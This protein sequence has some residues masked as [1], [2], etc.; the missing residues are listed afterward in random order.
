MKK[1]FILFSLILFVTAGCSKEGDNCK[2]RADYG[3][4][5]PDCHD[6]YRPIIF[7]HGFLG[8]GDNYANMVQRFIQNGYCPEKLILYDW[9]TQSGDV[10]LAV[11]NLSLLIDTVI[12]KS[13][14]SQVDLIGHSM[15]GLVGSMYLNREGSVSKIA[16]YVHAASFPDA[17]FP[18]GVHVMTISSHDDTVVGFTDIPGAIN[19][20][21]PG[22]DHIQVVTLPY[23]FQKVYEFFNDGVP[24][25]SIEIKKEDEV[26]IEGKALSIGE[27]VPVK[28]ARIEIYPVDPA[29]G[30]RLSDKSSACFI[31]DDEGKWGIFRPQK[32]TYYEIYFET[33]D[34][35]RFHYYRQPFLQSQNA[36]YLRNLG[37]GAGLVGSLLSN[38]AI[39]SDEYSVMVMFS[40]NQAIYYGRD[41]ISIDGNNLATPE[42]TEP[43]QSS[44]AFFFGDEN[45]NG[46]S[47]LTR[48]PL[49][50][51][52]FLE[53]IDY[54]ISTETRKPVIFEF[55]GKYLAVPNWKSESEGLGIAVFD[56]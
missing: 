35:E 30:E 8:A 19:V 28:D 22:A 46:I 20:E 53:D 9:N 10:T 38:I 51:I 41:T 55:N 32:D 5:I 40:S 2:K 3:D 34:G 1:I 12:E 39:Y 45:Q 7:V 21:I 6:S 18:D 44:L 29:S 13:G 15:G 4:L 52:P 14:F 50:A 49:S 54:Y 36:V 11:D 56:Y 48:G 42:I 47:D 17:R 25:E 24:P 16:H 31:T 33:T 26:W 43:S 23:S 37:A 27:N